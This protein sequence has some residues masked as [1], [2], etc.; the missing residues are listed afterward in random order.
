M[1]TFVFK[2]NGGAGAAGQIVIPF[3]LG[4]TTAQAARAI[5]NAVNGAGLLNANGAAIYADVYEDRVM[6][7]GAE[8]LTKSA[9]ATISTQALR[10]WAPP[11]SW[12]APRSST[13]RSSR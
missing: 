10:P 3:A 7:N 1:Q 12:P 8:A 4:E 9:N 2:K 11:P 6:L 13:A 5:A